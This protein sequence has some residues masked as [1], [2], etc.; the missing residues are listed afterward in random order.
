MV[1]SSLFMSG[2]DLERKERDWQR[3]WGKAAP[4][5]RP[6][7]RADL[8]PNEALHPLSV[9]ASEAKQSITP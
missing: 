1:S 8:Q 6:R 4:R 9:I 2:A 7:Q 5:G 3:Y